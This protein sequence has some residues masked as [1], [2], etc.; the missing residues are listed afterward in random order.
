MH[1]ARTTKGG[2]VFSARHNDRNFNVTKAKHIDAAREKSNEYFWLDGKNFLE[3]EK[4]F[5]KK[6]FAATIAKKNERA[7]VARHPERIITVDDYRDNPRTCPEETILQIGGKD[8]HAAADVLL[9]IVNEFVDW[10][11]RTFPQ[12]KILDVA[13]HTDETTPHA[14]LRRVWTATDEDGD[15]YV[16]ERACLRQMGIERPDLSRKES[17]HNNA[18][19]TYTQR[20]RTAWEEI[21]KSHGFKLDEG[22]IEKSKTGHDLLQ[23]KAAQDAKKIEALENAVKEHYFCVAA[24]AVLEPDLYQNLDHA[25]E[26]AADSLLPDISAA[27]LAKKLSNV[28]SEHQKN[29]QR[30]KKT[31]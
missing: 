11:L 25:A 7:L 4:I 22:R 13:I 12:V 24:K 5:Y 29:M 19:I 31:S 14:H 20:C 6:N 21:V 26:L 27:E 23:F 1:N 16:S 28:Q 8:N 15:L 10:H 18:K 9:D 17:K 30:Q 3:S 2:R